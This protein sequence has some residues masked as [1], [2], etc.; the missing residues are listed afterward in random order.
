M[1]A[2]CPHSPLQT[3]QDADERTRRALLDFSYNLAVGNMDD[4]FR[5]IKAIKNPGVWENMA[6][7]C[8]KNK[9]LDVAG[10]GLRGA[11]LVRCDHEA[12]LCVCVGGRS[13]CWGRA[14]SD[15]MVALL[16]ACWMCTQHTGTCLGPPVCPSSGVRLSVRE[17]GGGTV[18][19]A[20]SRF[21][22]VYGRVPL[23]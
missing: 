17:P 18:E 9:R 12:R 2:A 16:D 1:P 8:I 20:L 5:S 3:P 21:N 22:L 4:A 19:S 13:D 10:A 6:H 14:T 23:P 7:L 11:A 15:G